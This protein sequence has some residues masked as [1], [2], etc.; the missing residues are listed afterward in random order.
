MM[1]QFYLRFL[2]AVLVLLTMASATTTPQGQKAKSTPVPQAATFR[3]VFPKDPSVLDAKRDLGAKGDGVTDDTDA[4]QKGIDA[5][6]GIGGPTRVLYLPNGVYRVTRTLVVN[7]AIGPW[8]YG[9]TRDGVIIRLDDGVKDCN[10]VIRTHP[11]ESGPT[12]ADWFM[13]NLY[14]FTVD[15]GNNPETDGIR[16]CA[17]NTG[18]I[19]NVRVI[20]R[21]KVGINAGFIDQSSPNLIQDVVIDGFETGIVCQWNWGHTLSRI[22]I[23]N[24]RKLGVYVSGTAVGIE[25]LTV[26][27][28][29]LGLFCDFPNDWTWW[30][31]VVALVNARFTIRTPGDHAIHNR[32]V[33]YA[34]NVRTRGYRLAL[35]GETAGGDVKTPVIE[36]YISHEVKKLF[37]A[38]Q[39]ALQL[40]IKREPAVA[41]ETN[42]ARWVCA[43]DFGAK[44]G[45]N[46]DDSEAIQKAIDAAAA[47]G[48]TTVYL[49]G[50][51]GADPNWYNLERPVR[52]HGSVRH[53]IG[54][55]FGR[56]MGG[57]EGRFVVDDRSA[58]VVK[59]QN[60]DSFG[61]PPVTLEN[62]SA[63]RTLVME[64]GGVRLVGN[65]GGDIFATNVSG[66]LELRKRGQKA[67]ARQLNPEGDS[68]VGLVQNRGGDLW[69]LGMKNEGRGVRV[70]TSDGG[71]TEVLG[72]FVYGFGTEDSDRRPLF[73]IVDA[74]LCVMG[75]REIAFAGNCYPVKV[76]EKRG[77][78]VRTLGSDRE[79]GWIGWALYSGWRTPT[80]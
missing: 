78:E 73:D 47:Q 59:F 37:D 27:N 16:W 30:G 14:N 38:P 17:T 22:T 64:S 69:V 66:F 72:M 31:G 9:E 61:G 12:S 46:Q 62:R 1:R 8:I 11:R 34:R 71:R 68:D 7:A 5:S 28:T 39:R 32:S 54:L 29:P 42:P 55:G 26:E 43:N 24:C 65:G 6:C 70:L 63:S 10:A 21:G 13:R 50:I 53:I 75:L 25:D 60:L 79:Q 67:W 44:A 2:G 77:N 45:D 19:K 36:E 35:K 3:I 41:W 74:S 76:R 23:R 15:V 52:V 20:G 40:P 56:I 18:I 80:R 51:E 33:L 4:L 58:P 57:P 48:K 49:R